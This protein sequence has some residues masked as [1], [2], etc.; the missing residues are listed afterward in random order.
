MN[1]TTRQTAEFS[2]K[3]TSFLGWYFLDRPKEIV[4]TYAAYTRAF[5]EMFAIVFL[6]KTLFSPWKS[7]RDNYPDKGFNLTAILET[8]SMNVTTRSI[9]AAIRLATILAGIILQIALCTLF[10]AY[11]IAWLLFPLL[12]VCGIPLFLYLIV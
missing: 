9:G 12:L 5:G 3:R 8:W 7:I 1:T 10:I 2:F 6:L 4:G 11:L